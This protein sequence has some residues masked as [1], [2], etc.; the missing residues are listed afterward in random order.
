MEEFIP[1]TP[2]LMRLAWFL[3]LKDRSAFARASSGLY[4]HIRY[5]DAALCFM[6]D[7]HMRYRPVLQFLAIASIEADQLECSEY[8]WEYQHRHECLGKQWSPDTCTDLHQCVYACA[9]AKSTRMIQFHLSRVDMP[10][11]NV[12][13]GRTTLPSYFSSCVR[14]M[15][16]NLNLL[17]TWLWDVFHNTDKK[18]WDD[19]MHSALFEE[20]QVEHVL[21][22]MWVSS[23]RSGRNTLESLLREELIDYADNGEVVKMHYAESALGVYALMGDRKSEMINEWKRIQSYIQP[24]QTVVGTFLASLAKFTRYLDSVSGTDGIISA[25]YVETLNAFREIA[26]LIPLIVPDE[27]FPVMTVLVPIP[28]KVKKNV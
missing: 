13:Q 9:H 12:T 24:P 8:I 16:E 5:L 25:G 26:L 2:A 6:C 1:Y 18:Y 22:H 20:D 19:Q 14:G 15:C 4:N 23:L 3:P 7:A 10:R 11:T 27:A 17:D 21:E 28:K